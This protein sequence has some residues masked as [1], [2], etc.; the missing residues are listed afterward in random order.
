M[1]YII[2][3]YNRIFLRTIKYNRYTNSPW[4]SWCRLQTSA[5]KYT[6][7]PSRRPSPS[8]S[9]VSSRPSTMVWARSATRTRHSPE[10]SSAATRCRAMN[11]RPPVTAHHFFAS[12]GCDEPI[13]RYEI[14]HTWC[15]LRSSASLAVCVC[16]GRTHAVHVY[17]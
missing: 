12:A 10:R 1:E 13:D 15:Q 17:L 9:S 11:P 7:R 4:I 14:T 8:T 2:I 6:A 5:C 16:C 3:K